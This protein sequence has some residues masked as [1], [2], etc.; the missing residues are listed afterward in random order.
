MTQRK[1]TAKRSSSC[2]ASPVVRS[3]SRNAASNFRSCA[4]TE[5][6]F[7]ENCGQLMIALR[8]P[9]DLLRETGSIE[10]TNCLKASNPLLPSIFFNIIKGLWRRRD[11]Y[12][13]YKKVHLFLSLSSM[14]DMSTSAFEFFLMRARSTANSG[15]MLARYCSTLQLHSRHC[16]NSVSR[17]SGSNTLGR[18]NKRYQAFSSDDELLVLSFNSSNACAAVDA[19][20]DAASVAINIR[21]ANSAPSIAGCAGL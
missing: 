13:P 7:M 12:N 16:A 6:P 15:S 4:T 5:P 17:L 8:M 9:N 14:M 1:T 2:K 21:R 20:I 19:A 3:Y 10:R 11:A 18:G